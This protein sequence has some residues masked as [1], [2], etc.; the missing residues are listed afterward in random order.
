MRIGS[1]H[2][3]SPTAASRSRTTSSRSGGGFADTLNTAVASKATSSG[4]SPPELSASTY[5][6]FASVFMERGDSEAAARYLA[7]VPDARE[8]GLPV[9]PTGV[10]AENGR[11]DYNSAAAAL[12]ETGVFD[13]ATGQGARTFDPY[14]MPQ[15]TP[16]P[17][18][19]RP[20]ETAAGTTRT[21]A[22][23]ADLA[24][25]LR[26]RGGAATTSTASA[27]RASVEGSLID[28]IG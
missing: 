9:V 11:W 20:T 18:G 22:T 7:K 16:E 19:R 24:E 1:D 10:L 25:R 3:T 14:V 13:S 8:A 21:P 5:R 27:V 15:S 6:L 17:D 4:G 12:P 2:A 28:R 23:P 26:Y